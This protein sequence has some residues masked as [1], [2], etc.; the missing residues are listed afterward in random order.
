[1]YITA[2]HFCKLYFLFMYIYIGTHKRI[3]TLN[4]TLNLYKKCSAQVIQ[5]TNV[6]KYL[7]KNRKIGT[8]RFVS[9]V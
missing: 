6:N 9:K 1:M 4:K 3:H 2:T 8:S 5:N 7:A